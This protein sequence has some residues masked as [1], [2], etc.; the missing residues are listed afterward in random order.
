LYIFGYLLKLRIESGIFFKNNYIYFKNLTTLKKNLKTRKF[1]Q[2]EEKKH[3]KNSP[4]HKISPKK[5]L[6]STQDYVVVES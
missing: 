3:I 2:F 6:L 5:S 4:F 1:R